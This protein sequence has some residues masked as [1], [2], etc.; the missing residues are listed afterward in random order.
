MKRLLLFL[1]FLVAACTDTPAD[2]TM[3]PAPSMAKIAPHTCVLADGTENPT[4]FDEYGYNRCAHIFNGTGESWSLQKGL[5]AD[6]LGIYAPDKL[7]MKWNEQWDICNFDRSPENCAGAWEDNEWNGKQGGSGEVWHYKIKWS[8]ACAAGEP[9]T[10]GGY[11]IWGEYEVLMD[12]GQDPNVGPGHLW[13]A[14]AVPNGY[15]G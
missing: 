4:G 2:P 9:L 14:H 13:F 3:V 8:A 15:G 10:D 5:P 11:C 1:P 6:Y 12:Q 7:V